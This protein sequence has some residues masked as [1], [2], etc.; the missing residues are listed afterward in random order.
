MAI[1]LAFAQTNCQASFSAYAGS[2]NLGGVAAGA[3]QSTVRAGV[4]YNPSVIDTCT[5]ILATGSGTASI[6][7][8]LIPFGSSEC[9]TTGPPIISSVFDGQT[10]PDRIESSSVM[11]SAQNTVSFPNGGRYTICYYSSYFATLSLPQFTILPLII[12]V[13]GISG[14]PYK[15]F[16][17]ASNMLPCSAYLG[18]Y[19]LLGD[20]SW[21]LAVT[22][23]T[24]PACGSSA[25]LNP[26]SSPSISASVTTS[27]STYEI[28]AFGTRDIT[29]SPASYKACYCAG[30]QA[31]RRSDGSFCTTDSAGYSNYL[32]NVGNIIMVS[33]IVKDSRSGN[34]VSIYPRMR[35]NLQ[36][37]CGSGGCAS[38]TSPRIKIIES[39]PTNNM[40]PYYDESAGCRSALQ[41]TRYMSPTNC[42][43][44]TFTCNLVRS[45]LA[46]SPDTSLAP[47]WNNVKVDSELSNN[48]RISRS[49]DVCYCDSNCSSSS[50]WFY[51]A[52]VS[53][54]AL[55]IRFWDPYSSST[56]L[57]ILEINR[58][59]IV[60]IFAVSSGPLAVAGSL[61]RE[62]KLIRDNT[63]AMSSDSCFTAVQPSSVSGHGCYSTTDCEN[64]VLTSTSSI[65]YGPLYVSQAGWWGV[66]YCNELCVSDS[67]NWLLIG[68]TLVPGPTG[69]DQWYVTQSQAFS[70][71]ISG[72]GLSS[73]N[74]ITIIPQSASCTD[75]ATGQTSQPSTVI[76][77]TVAGATVVGG[78]SIVSITDQIQAGLPYTYPS[79]SVVTFGANH[80]LSPGDWITLSGV[81]TT[82]NQIDSMF[83]N[84][85]KI[86]SVLDDH[87]VTVPISFYSGMFPSI[88]NV[89]SA[90]WTR[91]N[92]QVFSSLFSSAIGTYTV[93]WRPSLG[94]VSVPI[95][96]GTLTVSA[97]PSDSLGSIT[98][99]SNIAGVITPAI[100]KFSTGP[101][102]N[103]DAILT[104]PIVRIVFTNP[105]LIKPVSA[106]DGS[107]PIDPTTLPSTLSTA[108]PDVCS[109][110]IAEATIPFPMGCFVVVDTTSGQTRWEVNVVFETGN[111][112]AANR[113]YTIVFMSTTSVGWGVAGDSA[114]E[115]WAMD[116]VINISPYSVIEK[117]TLFPSKP[118]TSVSGTI[119]ST[120]TSVT[121]PYPGPVRYIPG[122]CSRT[123]PAVIKQCI[124]CVIETDCG[125]VLGSTNW[126][127]SSSGCTPANQLTQFTFALGNTGPSALV[128]GSTVTLLFS[129]L[130]DWDMT[131]S[132]QVYVKCTSQTVGKNCA[133][134]SLTFTWTS[135]SIKITLP[136]SMDPVASGTTYT[137][138]VAGLSLP[139]NGFQSGTLYFH[140][141]DPQGNPIGFT[142]SPG[143][144]VGPRFSSIS[145]L[146]TDGNT[147]PF[148]GDT[149]NILY[150]KL[151]P[152]FNVRPATTLIITM[153]TGYVCRQYAVTGCVAADTYCMFSGNVPSSLTEFSNKH[154][155]GRSQIGSRQIGWDST[156]ASW[157]G[158][159]TNTCSLT[160]SSSTTIFSSTT[161]IYISLMVD[162]P[163]SA[164]LQTDS[165]N[166]WTMSAQWSDI[167]SGT[168]L[169]IPPQHF[170]NNLAVIGSLTNQV[171]VPS[172]FAL[173]ATGNNLYVFFQTTTRCVDSETLSAQIIVDAPS[174]FDFGQAC[175][176]AQLDSSI[177]NVVEGDANQSVTLPLPTPQDS[178]FIESI[179]CTGV[180]TSS[181]TY[182]R[183]IINMANGGGLVAGA[184]YGFRLLVH[185]PSVAPSQNFW[186]ITT[187]RNPKS[188]CDGSIG[189]VPMIKGTSDSW[190]LYS[191][192]MARGSMTV[193]VASMQPFVASTTLVSVGP[194]FVSKATMT[195]FRITAPPGYIWSF[196]PATFQYKAPLDG[197]QPTPAQVIQAFR[198][199][200]SLPLS[201]L[202][203][204]PVLPSPQ[205]VLEF[206][207]L[208]S[209]L[210][211]ANTYGFSAGIKVPRR[212]PNSGP[213][214]FIVEFGYNA[215][216]S[217]AIVL[218][219][220]RVQSV[221][222]G[223]YDDTSLIVGST[224]SICLGFQTITTIPRGGAIRV[225][226]P[227][228]GFTFPGAPVCVPRPW[229]NLYGNLP[230]VDSFC[231]V[232]ASNVVK[233]VAGPTG[234]VPALYQFCFQVVNP[235][236][237]TGGVRGV[238]TVDTLSVAAVDTSVL[239]FSTSIAGS[240]VATQFTASL[241]IQ[242]EKLECQTSGVSACTPFDVSY[243]TTGRNDRP[244]K[245]NSLIFDIMTP[246]TAS[247][248]TGFP[249]LTIRA[250]AGFIFDKYC[251]FIVTD[252]LGPDVVYPPGYTTNPVPV[253]SCLGEGR[254]ATLTLTSPLILGLRYLIGLKVTNPSTTPGANFW[255]I[256]Y[257]EFGSLP[258]PGLSVWALEDTDSTP[259]NFAAN[260][261]NIVRFSISPLNG[262][263]V[264][265]F[266]AVSGPAGFSIDTLCTAVIT[267]GGTTE[268]IPSSCAG[269]ATPSNQATITLTTTPL[270][271]GGVVYQ[272]AL[273]VHN[274][275]AFISSSQAGQWILT[276]YAR[277]AN[278]GILDSTAIPSF[279]VTR[280]IDLFSILSSTSQSGTESVTYTMQFAL[281]ITAEPGDQLEVRFPTGF[282][283]N[284]YGK[285]SC[286]GFTLLTYNGAA[287]PPTL[288]GIS[289]LCGGNSLMLT[290]AS[291]S[292]ITS[293]S[294]I[295]FLINTVNPSTQPVPNV[296]LLT[297][298]STKLGSVVA[299]RLID[300]FS[301]YPKLI[302]PSLV[303]GTVPAIAGSNSL[304]MLNISFAPLSTANMISLS[305]TNSIFSTIYAD[306]SDLGVVVT[307]IF[308]TSISP[309]SI[310]SRFPKNITLG[311]IAMVPGTSVSLVI[312]N[313]RNPST[314]GTTKWHLTT[315]MSSMSNKRDEIWNVDGPR[316]LGKIT[317]LPNLCSVTPNLYKSVKARAIFAFTTSIDLDA[318]SI[319]VLT[320]PPGYVL[321]ESSFIE[322]MGVYLSESGSASSG[323]QYFALN[324]LI[325][326]GS[327]NFFAVSL[328]TPSELQ[329]DTSWYFDVFPPGTS[330]DLL[331]SSMSR[332]ATNDELFAGFN[333]VGVMPFVLSPENYAPSS[334]IALQVDYRLP[335]AV[336]GINSVT[337]S[338]M[339]P[340]GF[341]FQSSCL[342]ASSSSTST[343]PVF[344]SCF[345]SG[346]TANLTT[347]TNVLPTGSGSFKVSGYNPGGTPNDNTW[348]LGAVADSAPNVFANMDTVSGYTIQSLATSFIGGN[349][350]AAQ[351]L[352]FFTFS[353]T[354]TVAVTTSF[355]RV[356]ITPHV[357]SGYALICTPT[358]QVGMP[359]MPTCVGT[360]SLESSITINVP[361]ISSSMVGAGT[362]FC[363]GVAVNNPS[364]PV[365]S[366]ANSFSLVVIDPSTGTTI[367]A[368]SQVSGTNLK[369]TPI[370]GAAMRYQ[371]SMRNSL[372]LVEVEFT[373]D[374]IIMSSSITDIYS[375]KI[376]APSGFIISAASSVKT[377]SSL[378]L[379]KILP[380][381]VSGNV[382]T[383][384][385]DPSTAT[386]PG[387][388]VIQFP[389]MN[390]GSTPVENFWLIQL[391]L[392]SNLMY[393]S[394]I[395]GYQLTSS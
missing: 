264:G 305:G 122:Y 326:A 372:S 112:L 227:P 15:I 81:S 281:P 95:F 288:S 381:T 338:L 49:L 151:V 323:R 365:L 182:N 138:S 319:I 260:E 42:D 89:A 6:L 148:A 286:Q 253:A 162:N 96:A 20:G 233:I 146:S 50:N 108:R 304:T 225:T 157:S 171:I 346:N 273:T 144:V 181:N 226:P 298:Y 278:S 35:V 316:I 164:L 60:E 375:L 369:A 352:G 67:S 223:Q 328:N 58:A 386:P 183:A 321:I 251:Q 126:C 387:K 315:Y 324:T 306:F 256:T 366:Q 368:N 268:I 353:I 26:F 284:G 292:T 2:S 139:P 199:T 373:A 155:S 94:S 51:V 356:V 103:Y 220:P 243:W 16:C 167:V 342:I 245:L 242:D 177:Y 203:V 271:G 36:I 134:D 361:I 237:P 24:S 53:V 173:G 376:T 188:Q 244:N 114:V 382:L 77:P 186:N 258:S 92:K 191:A 202:P 274:P 131:S 88:V 229:N 388:Y 153:P 363:V 345:G 33:V 106:V 91:T 339:A 87:R 272:V 174:G 74:T 175:T 65:Q 17:L 154:P 66:C 348:T 357:G 249:V 145:L 250:P 198:P 40:K 38:D 207:F 277:D 276:S 52:T 300:G 303:F 236:T 241:I 317:I 311:Q 5:N 392:E 378:A 308:S 294:V 205:N 28:H 159:G 263:P 385:L 384:S 360:G 110:L 156:V 98:L 129:P 160:L 217:E 137:Y 336:V 232:T 255:T 287:P 150:L 246:A 340:V 56:V 195:D 192:D 370:S 84:N 240:I 72:W 123:G 109:R 296:F 83:N 21:K 364:L 62:M 209:N 341:Q 44:I 118:V 12:D 309:L 130:L 143:W 119:V 322:I 180:S 102:P 115:I 10:S 133:S 31:T 231:S 1:E 194:F 172:T 41:S 125:G 259:T 73:Q 254:I 7:A 212:T 261:V 169:S 165:L 289:P 22:L 208:T 332:S 64:G 394:P 193:S 266:L 179:S 59:T 327:R 252:V 54:L 395:A 19:G 330:V 379:A 117:F 163:S 104:N 295:V 200:L 270:Q 391:F 371:S 280:R 149:G 238:W 307:Q 127:S 185:N 222:N 99:G 161:A 14:T 37:L 63:Q 213:N 293:G 93:C 8:S 349:R 121:S 297:Q 184:T 265:G 124:P 247:S 219:A 75:L 79:V 377:S 166:I 275:A 4:P 152:G 215:Q 390:P 25:L 70:L 290:L 43:P 234:I 269:T 141:E 325:R 57:P 383:I 86:V 39:N 267:V 178:S 218:P 47:T 224:N 230:P 358:L 333:L 61:I 45:D 197:G 48:V 140:L 69:N 100:V 85:L 111:G 283:L 211:L 239:D 55:H 318:G 312:L 351:T 359:S 27:T 168:S 120:I 389:V 235:T 187:F 190:R 228:I 32:Q 347:T 302:N 380:I 337:V 334:S 23:Y 354:R 11:W 331:S 90:T 142:S 374:Q 113:N 299:S 9:P 355:L 97:P 313:V 350:L 116:D 68:W 29:Q 262:V 107:S 128:G 216:R 34:S 329:T 76:G 343:L 210:K 176:V 101:L 13:Q 147:K 135:Y 196:N 189:T 136:L 257:N 248:V 367:D 80:G 46:S 201:R 282:I 291:Q 362:K 214:V 132:S 18:G 3:Y 71:Q 320:P 393:D 335:N 105:L 310:V 279:Q 204:A 314:A 206:Q 301:I 285:R 78:T 82:D 344:A 158:G 170:T 30:Y 221:I